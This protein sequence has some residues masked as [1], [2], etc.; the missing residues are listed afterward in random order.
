M[1]SIVLSDVKCIDSL[2]YRT[3]FTRASS[4][5]PKKVRF[6]PA[7]NP[8]DDF[9]S[10]VRICVCRLHHSND[11]HFSLSPT[12]PECRPDTSVTFCYV[13]HFFGCWCP[14]GEL[15]PRHTFLCVGRNR[16]YTFLGTY[17]VFY[18]C[19]NQI[20]CCKEHFARSTQQLKNCFL[21]LGRFMPWRFITPRGV[22]GFIVLGTFIK[23][24]IITPF[25]SR[26]VFGYI[27][28]C[29]LGNETLQFST[30]WPGICTLARCIRALG[31]SINVYSFPTKIFESIHPGQKYCS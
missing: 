10:N 9:A 14:V 25:Q 5:P 23:R 11:R 31:F 19:R 29:L 30:S 28:L 15:Y 17:H 12:C 7:K 24:M 13:S 3:F 16:H 20:F 6:F 1:A 4:L 27:Y 2:A 8:I 18:A 21:V 22:I 26:S